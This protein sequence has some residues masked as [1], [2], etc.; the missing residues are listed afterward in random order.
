MIA[1]NDM[2]RVER[3]CLTAVSSSILAK[4]SEM[5]ILESVPLNDHQSL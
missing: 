5:N 2:M 1:M 3:S 4:A